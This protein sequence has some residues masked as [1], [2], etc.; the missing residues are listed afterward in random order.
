MLGRI[1]PKQI[2]NTYRGHWLGLVLFAAVVFVRFMMGFNSM[3]FTRYVATSADRIPLDKYGASADATIITMFALL[4]L[5]LFL[6]AL[7][8]ALALI[9]Y[10]A[11]IPLI[12][13]FLLFHEIGNKIINTI[14]PSERS[15]AASDV[16][17]YVVLGVIAATVLG[18]LLSVTG[19]RPSLK[20]I[21]AD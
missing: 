17:Y 16:G 6:P 2:D 19:K 3:V 8:G 21:A 15:A 20:P 5:S 7:L 14:Y 18:F 13:L 1:F 10:R 12:Y 9:R 4:G 11:M